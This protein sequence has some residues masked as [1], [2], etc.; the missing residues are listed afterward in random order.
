MTPSQKPRKKSEGE[1][2]S[3]IGIP[4]SPF[5]SE[6]LMTDL[7]R[8]LEEQ[9]FESIEEINAYLS[10]FSGSGQPIP[11]RAPA[12]PLEQAQELIYQ[13]WDSPARRQRIKLAKQALKLS[14]DCA[15]A[16][17]ILAEESL[18]PE[19]AIE[20]LEQG[21]AA[22]AR[23]IGDDGFT[24]YEGEFWGVLATR[25][26]MRVRLALGMALTALGNVDEANEQYREML[27]LNSNDNQGARYLL[28]VGLL[29]KENFDEAEALL[30]TYDEPTADC[31][32]TGALISFY[33]YGPTRKTTKRLEE[34][35]EMNPFAPAYL[36]GD[37][38]MP[39]SQPEYVALGE[40][41]EAVSYAAEFM[42]FWRRREGALEW[43]R[44][45]QGKQK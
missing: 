13:A 38:R 2:V 37:K 7:T 23:A 20:Y 33:R 32:Y 40:E 15:D 39:R 3:D 16:Y 22:G 1:I 41:S 43:L 45:V 10:K 19:E 14:E 24:N 5:N 34:A 12:T 30:A 8:L 6:K 31:M 35:I 11:S 4:A 21:V 9:E 44:E 25:P 29:S 28:L 27:R 17:L 26:Y 18:S 36:L 42:P